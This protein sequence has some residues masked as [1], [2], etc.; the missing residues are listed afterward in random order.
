M[1]PRLLDK[2]AS[3]TFRSYFE[4]SHDTDEILAEFGYSYR[5]ARLNLPKTQRPLADIDQL[6]TQIEAT[7]PYVQLTSEIAKREVLVA[8]VLTRVATI[9]HQILRFEYPLKVNNWLQGS[10]DYLIRAQHQIVVVEAKRDDLTR[11]FTQ[12]AV[13]MIALSMLDDAPRT[14]YGA[15]TMG[16]FWI[17]GVLDS[18]V[19]Q[20]TQDIG[21][22]QV[23]D[24]VENL[25]RVLVSIVDQ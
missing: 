17:F 9:C 24:D 21:G 14:I 3:Y 23:P 10:L 15:V 25:I 1:M 8:P 20:I 2:D 12:L 7:L 5:Q 18:D 19:K 4:L 11:G 22:Y 13:E 16:N 6:K